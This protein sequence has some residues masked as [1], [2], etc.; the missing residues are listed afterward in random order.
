MPDK[1]PVPEVMLEAELIQF[2][3]LD[4]LGVKNPSGSL[5]YYRECG[6]LQATKICGYNVYTRS[7]ALEFLKHLTGKNGEKT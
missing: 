4:E 6:K 7:S 1:T 3:R 2:L 5:R